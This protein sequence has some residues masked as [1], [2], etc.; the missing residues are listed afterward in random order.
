MQLSG[1]FGFRRLLKY[2]VPSI[3]MMIFTSVYGVVDGFFVSNKE[4]R[5][6][7]LFEP[8]NRLTQGGLTDMQIG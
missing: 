8:F 2:T 3:I 1:H 5:A 7:T 6:K 4:L